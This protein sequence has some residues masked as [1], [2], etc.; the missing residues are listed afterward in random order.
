MLIHP[1]LQAGFVVPGGD[2]DRDVGDLRAGLPLQAPQNLFGRAL[3]VQNLP[4]RLHDPTQLLGGNLPRDGLNDS[5]GCWPSED[6]RCQGGPLR[7]EESGSPGH[8]LRID[9]RFE[10]D[11]LHLGKGQL[12][13]SGAPSGATLGQLPCLPKNEGEFLVGVPTVFVVGHDNRIGVGGGRGKWEGTLS[14]KLATVAV[15]LL[16]DPQQ[17]ALVNQMGD[18]SPASGQAPPRLLRLHFT[19][20]EE[21]LIEGLGL[22]SRLFGGP[23]EAVL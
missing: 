23:T 1:H 13:G 12:P 18:P 8:Q 7:G 10:G 5:I 14:G 9:S 21:F 6:L 11:I 2:V 15:H 3:L 20:L 17:P 4:N 19:S 22:P 16:V